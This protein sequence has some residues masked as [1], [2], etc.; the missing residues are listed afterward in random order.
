MD[1]FQSR[2]LRLKYNQ[3]I[4]RDHTQDNQFSIKPAPKYWIKRK[5][6]FDTMPKLNISVYAAAQIVLISAEFAAIDRNIAFEFDL[7]SRQIELWIPHT[8]CTDRVRDLATQCRAWYLIANERRYEDRFL[9]ETRIHAIFEKYRKV[10]GN[11]IWY[12][13]TDGEKQSDGRWRIWRPNV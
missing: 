3:S 9:C 5:Q 11:S 10:L 2:Y 13:R 4:Q 6:K 12:T 1:F 8:T 7:H